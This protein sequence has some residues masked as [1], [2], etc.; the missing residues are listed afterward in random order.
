MYRELDDNELL[1]LVE[2]EQD[3][4]EILLKKYEPLINK[5]C[6]KYLLLGKKVGYELDDLIQFANIALFE[7]MNYFKDKKNVL[8][9]TYISK[10]IENKIKVEIRK[11]LTNK[12]KIL[13]ETISYDEVYKGTD[14][15]LVDLI[16][17]K[18]ILDPYEEL[19]LKEL[20]DKYILFIQSLP[21]E[22]A[23]AFEM[24]NEGYSIKQISEFLKTDSNTIR[25]SIQFA[26]R[27]ICLN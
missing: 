5:I 20:E 19:V 9:Y 26:K 24:K 11:Q 6:H 14:R 3:Y 15:P 12:R 22:V 1:F 27:R 7:A 4:Y 25:K 16:E 2:E 23:V 10:C 13:N 21:I 8:F 18:D 17:N